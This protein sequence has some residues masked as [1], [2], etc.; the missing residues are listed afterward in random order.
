MDPFFERQAGELPELPVEF[1]AHLRR[2]E[3]LRDEP[4]RRIFVFVGE[5]ECVLDEL[6]EEAP[7]G[8]AWPGG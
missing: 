7:R 2:L 8:N 4:I 3:G 6:V 1:S 5:T